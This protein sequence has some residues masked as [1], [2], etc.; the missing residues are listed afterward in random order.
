MRYEIDNRPAA[1]DFECDAVPAMRAVQNAKNLLMCKMGEIPYDRYRG[2]DQTLYDLP[3]QEFNER[4]LPELD[5]IWMWE[6][7]VELVSARA[8][9]TP[10]GEMLIQAVVEVTVE[11]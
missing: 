3:L 9:L 11:T 8:S 2:F 5:R 10:E 4:L 7:D 1:V 6:K